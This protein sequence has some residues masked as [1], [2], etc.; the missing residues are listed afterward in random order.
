MRGRQREEIREGNVTALRP[1]VRS[2]VVG[3]VIC[4]GVDLAEVKVVLGKREDA[5]ES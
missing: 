3:V 2:I 5:T 4:V 1:P